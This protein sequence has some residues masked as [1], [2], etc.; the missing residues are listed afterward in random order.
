MPDIAMMNRRTLLHLFLV[1]CAALMTA[2]GTM[3]SSKE[4]AG[5]WALANAQL[6]GKEFPIASLNGAMLHLTAKAYE[7]AGDSGGYVTVPDAKPAQLEIYG[8]RGPNAGRTIRAIYRLNGDEMDVC[9]Q[10]GD[11]P[12]PLEFVSPSGSQIFLVHYKRVQ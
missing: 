4:L 11:G 1:A 5:T 12:R 6:G 8:V 7:F 2:C 10:L 3:Q 9:Y